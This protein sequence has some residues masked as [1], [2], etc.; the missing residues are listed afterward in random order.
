M[1]KVLFVCILFCSFFGS[2]QKTIQFADPLPPNY[3]LVPQVDKANFGTYKSPVSGT[4]YLFDETGI[5]IV[6][7]ITAYITREQLR[8]SSTILQRNGYLFG[9]VQ[10]DSIP[11]VA[12]G[13]RFYYGIRTRQVLVGEGGQ[14]RLT[15]LDSKTYI[16]NFLEGN[17]FE[18]SL[19]T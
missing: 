12:E 2:A 7:V 9:I 19:F 14:H 4:V 5:S 11:C 8:E 17:F 1:K 15:R 6:S 10:G 18:P 16:V 3:K 13:E